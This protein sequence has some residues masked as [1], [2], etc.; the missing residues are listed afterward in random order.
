MGEKSP[1][2]DL[3]SG[4]PEALMYRPWSIALHPILK[5]S[6]KIRNYFL[7]NPVEKPLI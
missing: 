1:A 6:R 3:I 7:F 5:S 4:G 2:G